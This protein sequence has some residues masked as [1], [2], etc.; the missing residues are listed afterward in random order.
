MTR[1]AMHARLSFALLALAAVA[2]PLH[3]QQP[4]TPADARRILSA[5]A[6][7]SMQGR[8]TGTEGAH[9]AAKYIAGEMNR[10]GL[11]S[12]G[13]SVFFQRVP[14]SMVEAA[15]GRGARPQLMTAFADLDSIPAARRRT[16]VN[17]LGMIPGSDPVLA[18][19][20]VLVDAHYDHLGMRGPGVNGDSIFN[21]ADDD[22]SGV[23]AVLEI[24]RHI[25]QGP[26]PKRTIIF[27]AMVGEEVGLL[28]TNWFIQHPPIPLERFVANLEIEMIGRPDSLAFG[29]GKAWLTGF[30]RSTMGESFQAH[31]LMV[32]PDMRPN[33]S[34]FTRSD[35]IG[36]ARR[37]IVAH[38]LS[39][40][41][42]HSDYHRV[43]DDVDKVDFAHMAAVIN[44]GAAA[45]RLLV[46]GPKPE[47]KPGGKP[48]AGRGGRRGGN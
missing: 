20:V 6:H 40:F 27:A 35:N 47:W 12:L 16:E 9:R 23:T 25:K 2:A 46:D 37:G 5:L 31:G 42:L 43:T 22:A 45:V 34:F 3:A 48:E 28:G 15:N 24:A 36:F 17:V 21:G 10:I 39:S 32:F 14:V 18:N 41:N 11:K 13:D 38:T 29:T 4:T 33:Q 7:D 19:E 26:P 1:S 8:A 44:T 30:E